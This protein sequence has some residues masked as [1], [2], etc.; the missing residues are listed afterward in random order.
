MKTLEI[1]GYREEKDKWTEI[2]IAM[3]DA[4]IRL[5]ASLRPHIEAF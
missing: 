3:V 2:Q 4:M 1:G 5:E